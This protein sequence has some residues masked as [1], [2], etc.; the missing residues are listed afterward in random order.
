MFT[1]DFIYGAFF[2]SPGIFFLVL[3]VWALVI[4][5]TIRWLNGTWLDA[6]WRMARRIRRRL[7]HL[8]FPNSGLGT[9]FPETPVSG[10]AEAQLKQ[11]IQSD[12]AKQEFRGEAFPNGSLG[13][14]ER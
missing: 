5:P 10:I 3:M 8:S 7:Q 2:F 9:Q 12:A 1:L 14:S 11:A 6:E 4:L 13:T